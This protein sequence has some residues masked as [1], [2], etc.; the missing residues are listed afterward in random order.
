VAA[1]KLP[2]P[3]SEIAAA[4]NEWI[5]GLKDRDRQRRDLMPSEVTERGIRSAL[6]EFIA[7]NGEFTASCVHLGEGVYTRPPQGSDRRLRCFVQAV[8]D[9]AG[10]PLNQLRILDLACLEGHYT[11]EFALHGAQAVGIEVREANVSKARFLKEQ[12]GLSN[13][14]FHQDDV[15]NLSE[16]KYGRFD[17]V[18]CAGFLYHLDAPAV[19]EVIQQIHDVCDR[20]AIFETFISLQ[21]KVSATH[22]GTTY[23]GNH[24]I[25]HRE[26][27]TPEQKYKDLWASIDNPSSF[28]LTQA[29]LCNALDHAG[30][31]SVYVQLNP[32]LEKHP[33][34]RRTFIA[35]KG[36]TASVLSSPVTDAE[37]RVDWSEKLQTPPSGEPN[38]RRSLAWRLA[39]NCLPKPVKDVIK[40]IGWKFGLIQKPNIPDFYRS[41]P[42]R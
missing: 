38:I 19:F 17:V 27:V 35:M 33:L 34:D 16:R 1:S 12:L 42:R 37:I 36:Q 18:L 31:T 13:V 26:G 5:G 4:F 20:L 32:S 14:E 29:S 24:Y 28:W 10:K 7:A 22:N 9:L 23:W 15:R 30:F 41:L 39:K 2:V 40:R 3:L 11:I 21:P 8:A 25:E 6:Q